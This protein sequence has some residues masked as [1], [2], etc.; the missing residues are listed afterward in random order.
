MKLTKML[1][2]N[3]A[4]GWN[5]QRN[6][7]DI[8]LSLILYLHKDIHSN[9]N[10]YITGKIIIFFLINNYLTETITVEKSLSFW[11]TSRIASPKNANSVIKPVWHS[12]NSETEVLST[13]GRCSYN[14][15]GLKLLI[16][17]W[18]YNYESC[19]SMYFKTSKPFSLCEK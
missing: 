5:H 9:Q 8:M 11:R 6:D 15:W 18:S 10:N 16:I 1:A 12:L 2:N 7:K 19:N 14:E 3:G 17:H 4:K 13:F